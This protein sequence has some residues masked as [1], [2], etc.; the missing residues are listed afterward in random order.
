MKVRFLSGSYGN[1]VF[2]SSVSVFEE[3]HSIVTEQFFRRHLATSLY[4]RSEMS[5]SGKNENF[6]R[7]GKRQETF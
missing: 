7:S 5:R 6:S 4:I 3:W 2:G 1:G